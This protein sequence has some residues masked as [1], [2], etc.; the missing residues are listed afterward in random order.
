MKFSMLSRLIALVFLSV[1]LT[2]AWK[3]YLHHFITLE[4]IQ[5]HQDALKHFINAH[6]GISCILYVIF[7]A[8][9][10]VCMLSLS[11]V[12][13]TLAGFLFNTSTALFLSISGAL[14]GCTLSFLT[15]RYL[16]PK[17]L[18][19]RYHTQ[20]EKFTHKFKEHGIRY[21]LTLYFFPLT[22]YPVIITVAGL[23]DISLPTFLATTAVGILPITLICVGAGK[24]LATI[25]SMREIMSAPVV[26][27]LTILSLIMIVPLF[28]HRTKK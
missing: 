22:P 6:Y 11:L 25:T 26:I 15:I 19:D 3:T 24:K 10:I 9:S 18:K 2:I 7:Y 20:L 13:T 21:L 5:S 28:I 8:T 12:L 4:Y 17:K 14:I 27:L 1:S 16:I 23:S